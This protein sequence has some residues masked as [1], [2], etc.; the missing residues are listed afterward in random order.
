MNPGEQFSFLIE[1][2]IAERMDRVISFNEGRTVSIEEQ[3]QDLIY[4]VECSRVE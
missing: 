2:I 3:G 4:T 1:K